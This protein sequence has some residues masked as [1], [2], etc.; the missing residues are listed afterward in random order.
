MTIKFLNDFQSYDTWKLKKKIK[1]EK[2][3][4]CHLC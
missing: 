1:V 3:K 4:L 2:S